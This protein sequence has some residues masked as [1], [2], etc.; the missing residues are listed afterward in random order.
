MPVARHG[1][2][3]RLL[4]QDLPRGGI[5]QIGAAH[6][7][8]HPL[9]GV[10]DHHRELV[11]PAAVGT[12][13]HEVADFGM[14]VLLLRATQ[15]IVE[16]DQVAGRYAEADGR[17][18]SRLPRNAAVV[19]AAAGSQFAA[20]AVADESLVAGQQHVQRGLV[21]LASSALPQD[22]AVVDQAERSQCLQL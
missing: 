1:Q 12:A 13:Q 5:E 7:F 9:R 16:A 20:A 15:A 18:R 8:G 6:H 2:A 17:I 10:V 3:Q 4:Q 19:D 11:G 22:R 21:G 14:H